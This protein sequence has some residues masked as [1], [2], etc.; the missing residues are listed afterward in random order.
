[1]DVI[2]TDKRRNPDSNRNPSCLNWSQNKAYTL[3]RWTLISRGN[4]RGITASSIGAPRTD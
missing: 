4:P 3:G 1:M 2:D